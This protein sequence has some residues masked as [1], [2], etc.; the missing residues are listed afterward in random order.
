MSNLGSLF[1]VSS[2]GDDDDYV[3]SSMDYNIQSSGEGPG[4][5]RGGGSDSEEESFTFSKV[6]KA[7]PSSVFSPPSKAS[8]A[9]PSTQRD[10][11]KYVPPKEP[12]KN[13]EGILKKPKRAMATASP[14]PKASSAPAQAPQAQPGQPSII[15]SAPVYLFRSTT[16]PTAF[17][18]YPNNTPLGLVVLHQEKGE[19]ETTT[20][21]LIYDGQK[22]PMVHCKVRGGARSTSDVP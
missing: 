18:P 9:M 2:G 17:Q 5:G 19:G 13:K 4:T 11:L 3:G 15:F 14:Q 10:S 7:P 1:G 21:L 16:K 20:T 6:K 12:K 22:K 8:T